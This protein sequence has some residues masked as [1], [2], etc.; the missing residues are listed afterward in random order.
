MTDEKADS[1]KAG[2]P[3][4]FDTPFVRQ[5]INTYGGRKDEL[6]GVSDTMQLWIQMDVAPL[7]L[8]IERL[9]ETETRTQ[10]H[11]SLAHWGQLDPVAYYSNSFVGEP[12]LGQPEWLPPANE[13][14]LCSFSQDVTGSIPFIIDQNTCRPE[15][16]HKQPTNWAPIVQCDKRHAPPKIPVTTESPCPVP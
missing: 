11:C 4:E 5:L 9:S 2:S 10:D 12:S 13:D 14:S 16:L 1:L 7:K 6:Y 15:D 8:N 3:G